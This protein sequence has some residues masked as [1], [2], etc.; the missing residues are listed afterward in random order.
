MRGP[1]P[2]WNQTF[3][4]PAKSTKSEIKF[5]IMKYDQFKVNGKIT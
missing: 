2:V 1:V 5:E 4:L 3:S